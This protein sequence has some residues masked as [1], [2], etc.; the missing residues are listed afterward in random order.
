MDSQIYEKPLE[1]MLYRCCLEKLLTY[2]LFH[3]IIYNEKQHSKISRYLI[4]NATLRI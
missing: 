2:L 4:K 1:Y 3:F